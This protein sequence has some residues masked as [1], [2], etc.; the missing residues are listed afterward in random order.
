M[1]VFT[2]TTLIELYSYNVVVVGRPGD[3]CSSLYP[4]AWV[5]ELFCCCVALELL[6]SWYEVNVNSCDWLKRHNHVEITSSTVDSIEQYEIIHINNTFGAPL[7]TITNTTHAHTHSANHAASVQH[8]WSTSSAPREPNR[9]CTDLT[10][11]QISQIRWC[12]SVN[13]ASS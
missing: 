2:F 3:Y 5:T 1:L 9:Y 4:L 13:Q 10:V 7:K 11:V 12:N 8:Q 6:N